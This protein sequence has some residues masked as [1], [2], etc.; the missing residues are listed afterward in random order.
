MIAAVN[1]S[2][3]DERLARLEKARPWSPR[4]V[5]KLES[6]IR[7]ADD[8]ALFRINPFNFA[9]GKNL[10]ENEVI[11]LLLYATAFG[12]FAMDWLLLC[13]QC[14]CVVE[15]FRSLRGVHNHFH[16]KLCQVDYEATL[17][18]FIAVTFTVSPEIREIAFHHPER[19]SASD[20]FFKLGSTRDGV[21]P[22]GTPFVNVQMALTRAV[23]FLPPKEVTRFD[24]E[25]TEGA[26]HC[27]SP[28]GKAALHYSIE[29]P[30]AA[31]QQVIEV[32]FEKEVK[33]HATGKIAP[34]HVTSNV[35]NAT[36]ERGTF[37][38][39]ILPP[40]IEVG[41]APVRFV[42]FLSGKRL[43]TTQ[44]FRDLFRAEVIRASEGIGVRD[45]ALLFTDLKG[46]TALYDRIGDLNAFSLVQQHFERLQQV[47]VRH[48]GAIIKTIGDAVM[49]AFLSPA[50]A[51]SAALA[52]RK[53]IASFNHG[54]PD[55]ELILK[56]GIHKG[57]AIAVTLNER[58]DYFGQTV[59]IAARVENLA[60]ADEIYL[61]ETVYEA[62]G[63]KP[64]LAPFSV[65]SKVAKLKGVQQ[66]LKVFCV[67]AAM[68]REG[69]SAPAA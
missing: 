27:V 23:G 59:N 51:V 3:L 9:R 47:T 57:A 62:E 45:I 24:V 6:H 38:V 18:D 64:E 11:D 56:I 14:S 50:D 66:D 52:M 67:G 32:R 63:V 28:E 30:P 13:A 29:G 8:E 33:G 49:A 31:E 5:S 1:E 69:A 16:C 17:D 22:D 53:E 48:N 60:D 36:D 15:S 55:R 37:L 68:G 20:Y 7:S 40:G 19:L 39:A 43:L 65:E 12:L 44:A 41:E 42:P 21:L 4:L 10:P 2:L 61:S 46:S 54:Q 34:G 26:I 35:E 25:A 58:L